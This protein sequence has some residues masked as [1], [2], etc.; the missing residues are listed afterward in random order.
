MY[1]VMSG[2]L[3]LELG[4]AKESLGCDNYGLG[5]EAMRNIRIVMRRGSP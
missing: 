3:Y 5:L 2:T 1:F 4:S